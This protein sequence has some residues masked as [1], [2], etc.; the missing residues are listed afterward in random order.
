MYTRNVKLPCRQPTAY[1]YF[2]LSTTHVV[3]CSV[4]L[5]PCFPLVLSSLRGH[6]CRLQGLPRDVDLV[7]LSWGRGECPGHEVTN[8]SS[9][10][11]ATKPTRN[12]T[13]AAGA[14]VSPSLYR[15]VSWP[16]VTQTTESNHAIVFFF[17]FSWFS[18]S[19]AVEIANRRAWHTQHLNR[20]A[21]P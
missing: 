19:I 15:G 11:T 21:T 8:V 18:E 13:A 14:N 1:L 2:V 17:F 7:Q 9:Y 4:C 3:P 5:M 10:C 6:I 16:D 20:R 12:M